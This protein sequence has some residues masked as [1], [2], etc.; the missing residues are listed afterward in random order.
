ME[1]LTLETISRPMNDKAVVR[2]SWYS[3][4]N[5]KSCLVNLTT[6]YSK[7]SGLVGEEK[8]VD[9]SYLDSARLLTLSPVRSLYRSC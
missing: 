3:F 8:A 4:T 6:F 2:G 9:V 5:K 7:M 1:Q